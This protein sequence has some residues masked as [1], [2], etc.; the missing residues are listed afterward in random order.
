MIIIISRR[1]DILLLLWFVD[2]KN[3]FCSPISREECQW[4]IMPQNVIRLFHA[5]N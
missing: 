4:F 5:V 2:S 1:I 3:I